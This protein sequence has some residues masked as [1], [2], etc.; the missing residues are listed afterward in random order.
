MMEF[1][2]IGDFASDR[3]AT[4]VIVAMSH[5]LMLVIPR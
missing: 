2:E 5:L 4:R 1:I 3:N